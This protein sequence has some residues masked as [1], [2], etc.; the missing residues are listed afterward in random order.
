[1]N[2]ASISPATTG[3]MQQMQVKE[4]HAAHFHAAPENGRPADTVEIHPGRA[5]RSAMQRDNAVKTVTMQAQMLRRMAERII[6][7]QY[8]KGNQLYM[9]LYGNKAVQLDPS[10]RP[11]SFIPDYVP[12]QHQ[13]AVANAIEYFS[14]A[15]TGRRILDTAE[16]VAGGADTLRQQPVMLDAFQNAVNTAFLNVQNETGAGILP[17]LTQRTF[18]VAMQGF[19]ALKTPIAS[20]E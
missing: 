10:L 5:N 6:K 8:S 15:Q 11:E 17:D 12:E 9:L 4:P 20:G 7:E 13:E 18:D 2:V 1:M 3:A 16:D 14:P 19:S